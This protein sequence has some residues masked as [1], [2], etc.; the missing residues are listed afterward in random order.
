MYSEDTELLCH[1][2]FERDVSILDMRL[3]HRDESND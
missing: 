1:D 2:S 3:V